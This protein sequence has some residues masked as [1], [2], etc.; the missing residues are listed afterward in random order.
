MEALALCLAHSDHPTNDCSGHCGPGHRHLSLVPVIKVGLSL[1]CPRSV[2]E[3][4]TVV[5]LD[6]RSCQHHHLP[7]PAQSPRLFSS[8]LIFFGHAS[9]HV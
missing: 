3:T 5:L 9:R 8:Y 6:F 7:P 4:L 2:S 1:S